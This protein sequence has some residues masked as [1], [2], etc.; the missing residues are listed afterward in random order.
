MVSEL[1]APAVSWDHTVQFYDEIDELSTTVAGFLADALLENGTAVV[2]ALPEHCDGFRR[3]L[4]HIGINVDSVDRDGRFIVLD[5]EETLAGI[6]RDGRVDDVRFEAIVGKLV[7]DACPRGPVHCFGEMVGVLVDRADIAAAIDLEDH[8]NA[9]GTR[10]PFSLLCGYA[11]GSLAAL[12]S[13]APVADDAEVSRRFPMFAGSAG[14]A[15]R[16][17]DATLAAWGLVDL[18]H[19]CRLVVSEL[20]TNAVRHAGSDFT[21]SLTHHDHTVVVCVGD[22]STVRPLPRPLAPHAV[23]GRGLHL[24]AASSDDWDV[25]LVDGGKLVCARITRCA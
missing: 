14:A 13:G 22:A 1:V 17:V 8:W 5:A 16:F 2:V 11:T 12:V 21:V 4:V 24:V 3:A 9:L 19:T 6:M 25:R 10:M 20:A 7:A 15:R 23:D 18:R